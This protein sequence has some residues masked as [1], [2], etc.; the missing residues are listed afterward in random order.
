MT[1]A[2]YRIATFDCYGTLIDWEGGVGQFLYDLALEF[3][4]PTPDNGRALRERW[5]AI[6]FDVI[7]GPYRDY[8]TVLAE[9]LRRWMDERG[10]PWSPERGAA[11]A[12]SMRSWQPFPDTVPALRQARAAGLR[13]A[14][15]SNTDNDLIAHSLRHLEVG[16]DEVVTAEDCGSYKPSLA[17]FEQLLARIGEAPTRVLH[18]A[19]GYKYDIGPAKRLGM[20]TA[21]INR[22]AEPIPGADQ[23]DCVWRDLWGLAQFAGGPG[24]GF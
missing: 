12:R 17:N 11:L 21:W 8:K 22:H 9:S 4:D 3:G 7:G 1:A 6:Q 14:I 24:P 15:L 2:P 16:F 20:A 10:Y 19:F 13:L 18:V 23:P 5:E